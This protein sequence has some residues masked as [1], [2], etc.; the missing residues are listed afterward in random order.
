MTKNEEQKLKQSVF[1]QPSTKGSVQMN[2]ARILL[3]YTN[4]LITCYVFG[5][6]KLKSQ[7]KSKI[8]KKRR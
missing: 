8:F 1:S 6:M 5:L 4:R 3:A 2:F 7:I